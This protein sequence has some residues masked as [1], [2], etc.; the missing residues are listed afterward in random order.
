MNAPNDRV[1]AA[2]EQQQH[3]NVTDNNSDSPRVHFGTLP[4]RGSRAGVNFGG[5][6]YGNTGRGGGQGG[7]E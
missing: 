3:G 7:R 6:R 1:V 5:G 4:G 2:V